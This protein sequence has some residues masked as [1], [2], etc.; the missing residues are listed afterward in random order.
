[1]LTPALEDVA[2]DQSPFDGD[3]IP[4]IALAHSFSMNAAQSMG[5]VAFCIMTETRAALGRSS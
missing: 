1:M 3:G 4:E 5:D 2:R